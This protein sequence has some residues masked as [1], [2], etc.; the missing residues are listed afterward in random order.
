MRICSTIGQAGSQV[1]KKGASEI[2]R[3]TPI[4]SP[5]VG[6][7]DLSSRS[8]H[9]TIATMAP[10]KKFP[11]PFAPISEEEE[12]II[13]SSSYKVRQ[14]VAFRGSF[15]S[16]HPV[17]ACNMIKIF[18]TEARRHVDKHQFKEANGYFNSI[19]EDHINPIYEILMIDMYEN[20]NGRV[21][22][23]YFNIIGKFQRLSVNPSKAKNKELIESMDNLYKMLGS[24]S[25][26]IIFEKQ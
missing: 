11:I 22:K 16:R 14:E 25:E 18:L 26:R 21:A 17:H 4:S 13:R 20:P 12:A 5:L 10:V 23:K 2:N 1:G 24:F 3:F 6:W 7:K 19:R 9:T 8:F 15:Y